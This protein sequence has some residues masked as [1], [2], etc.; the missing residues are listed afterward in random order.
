MKKSDKADKGGGR[1]KS[2]I[3]REK[4]QVRHPTTSTNDA[5]RFEACHRFLSILFPRSIRK[6]SPFQ[7]KTFFFGHGNVERCRT[8]LERRG[9][10]DQ[11]SPIRTDET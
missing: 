11:T 5:T 1:G 3:K 9:N 8:L 6:G 10:E 2:E 7:M 4:V